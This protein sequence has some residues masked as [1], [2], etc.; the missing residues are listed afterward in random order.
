[1]QDVSKEERSFTWHYLGEDIEITYSLY[2]YTPEF[3]ADLED[4]VGDSEF[5]TRGIVESVLHIVISWDIYDGEDVVPL[6]TEGL[7]KVP[8][9]V[10]GDLMQAISEDAG[11]DEEEGK[12]SGGRSQRNREQRR[13]RGG[14]SSRQQGSFA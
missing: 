11:G 5:V 3:E 2:R 13:H 4:L 7:Q 1:L 9:R 14:T 6:T 12:S 8:V 10:L